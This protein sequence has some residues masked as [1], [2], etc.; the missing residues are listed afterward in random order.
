MS[1]NK[2]PWLLALRFFP[3]EEG[4]LPVFSV[5]ALPVGWLSC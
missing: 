5:P 3:R 4:L 1:H 2:F